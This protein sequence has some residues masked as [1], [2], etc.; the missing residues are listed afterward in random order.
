MK[1]Q[2]YLLI[3]V[4]CA[5][6]YEKRKEVGWRSDVVAYQN[7]MEEQLEQVLIISW[8]IQGCECN[9]SISKKS[10][11]HHS[12]IGNGVLYKAKLSHY[13]LQT[14]RFN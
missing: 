13:D 14:T 7:H 4:Y 6:L 5:D 8:R 1:R 2:R 10:E 9:Y 3:H 12:E 11:A